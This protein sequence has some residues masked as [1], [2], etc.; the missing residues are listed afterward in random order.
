MVQQKRRAEEGEPGDQD[1]AENHNLRDDDVHGVQHAESYSYPPNKFRRTPGGAWGGRAR[2]E[3]TERTLAHQQE[4]ARRNALPVM[5]MRRDNHD[6]GRGGG[7]SGGS[8]GG[9]GRPGNVHLSPERSSAS[10]RTVHGADASPPHQRQQQWSGQRRAVSPSHV[11]R[12]DV[13]VP[14]VD[15]Y[16]NGREAPSGSS[17]SP[18]RASGGSMSWSKRRESE[19]GGR[20]GPGPGPAV[21]ISRP[22]QDQGVDGRGRER[23]DAGG[24]RG[25]GGGRGSGGRSG[26]GDY[27]LSAVVPRAASAGGRGSG[28]VAPEEAEAAYLDFER[29]RPGSGRRIFGGGGPAP[30]T[31]VRES[32]SG[33]WD[34]DRANGPGRFAK[35][36]YW[37]H[38]SGGYPRWDPRGVPDAERRGEDLRAWS[39]MDH[40]GAM[41]EQGDPDGEYNEVCHINSSMR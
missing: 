22:F 20:G 28:S 25:G 29:Y 19:G 26:D 33:Y 4:H 31:T 30:P 27:H 10:H 5:M 21:G 37:A 7:A 6:G 1:D 8:G 35:P 17:V 12:A 3:A 32:E 41:D 39:A 38:G 18:W 11:S 24:G 2:Q 23:G 40:P 15:P 16:K 34:Y 14:P 9:A 13:R 36:E